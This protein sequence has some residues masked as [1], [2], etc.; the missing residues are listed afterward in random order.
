MLKLIC[1]AVIYLL[2]VPNWNGGNLQASTWFAPD[3]D[4][5]LL[6][7]LVTN[8]ATQINELEQLITNAQKHTEMIERYNQIAKDHYYRSQRIHYIAESYVELSKR[9]PKDLEN[10]N[11]AIRALK[12]END[13]LLALINEYRKEESGNEKMEE[14]TAQREK[15]AQREIAFANSQVRRTGVISST[16]DAQKLTAQNTGLIYK[17][18][19]EMNQTN[20]AIVNKLSQQ[21]KLISRQM[22]DE[23]REE[24][25]K[26]KYYNLQDKQSKLARGE[27]GGKR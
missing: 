19:V 6:F 5:A 23:K 12:S 24:L 11:S 20:N 4:T 13:S 9:D 25:E 2:L 17:S 15:K 26:A 10:L 3:S 7:E 14:A 18:Q 22:K 8:T 27:V 1:P 16:N 21:N